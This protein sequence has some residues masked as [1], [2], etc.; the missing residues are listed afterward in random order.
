M[1]DDLNEIFD[2]D[3][4]GLTQKLVTDMEQCTLAAD[5]AREDL[6]VVVAQAKE[7]QFSRRD[8]Q[9]MKM[10]A[11]LRLDDKLGEAAEKLEALERFGQAVGCDLFALAG[12]AMTGLRAAVLEELVP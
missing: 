1:A 4:K 7:A 3:R 11:K 12:P 10:I 8:V 2:L 5:V 9:A 6:K